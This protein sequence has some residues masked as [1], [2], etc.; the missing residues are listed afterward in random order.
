MGCLLFE[1]PEPRELG[2][3]SA[4]CLLLGTEAWIVRGD[5]Y[6]SQIAQ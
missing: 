6:E 4:Q 5:R 2:A 1:R 3:V